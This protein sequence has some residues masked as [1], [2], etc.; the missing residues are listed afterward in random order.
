MKRLHRGKFLKGLE[1]RNLYFYRTGVHYPPGTW[2]PSL[3]KMFIKY[4]CSKVL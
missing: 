2:M 3:T 4:H 1:H